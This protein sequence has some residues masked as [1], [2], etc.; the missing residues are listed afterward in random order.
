[1]GEHW[2]GE[3]RPGRL[4]EASS[5]EVAQGTTWQARIGGAGHGRARSGEAGTVTPIH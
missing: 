5:D 2:S 3:V 4:G 1:M